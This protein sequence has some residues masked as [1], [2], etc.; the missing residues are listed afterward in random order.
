M[1][2]S[3]DRMSR[4]DVIGGGLWNV[5]KSLLGAAFLGSGLFLHHEQANITDEVILQYLQENRTKREP[6]YLGARSEIESRPICRVEPALAER[7][8]V[9]RFRF[10]ALRNQ[11]RRP[12]S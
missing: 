9:L 10:R 5:V 2:G 4:S 6:S 3:R 12:H 1:D 7:S 8:S 11:T